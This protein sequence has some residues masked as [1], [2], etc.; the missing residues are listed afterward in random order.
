MVTGGKYSLEDY[1]LHTIVS[2]PAGVFLPYSGVKTNVL[3]LEKT[4]RTQSIW[5]Y[6]VNPPYKLTKNK[7]IKYEHFQE[8]LDLLPGKTDSANSWTVP[9][10]AINNYDLSAKNPVKQQQEVRLGS[11]ELLGL[12]RADNLRINELLGEVEGVI[13]GTLK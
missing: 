12:I 1:N 11:E 8:F 4:G 9:V 6:E 2:L 5:Y 13:K 7:P 3:F 10:G